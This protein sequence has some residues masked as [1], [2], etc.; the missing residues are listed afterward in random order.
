MIKR[1]S[2]KIASAAILSVMAATA[3]A[4]PAKAATRV[5]TGLPSIAKKPVRAIGKRVCVTA[6]SY[7][8][9]CGR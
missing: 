8:H 1:I 4:A 6:G 5:V 9:P 7:R 2:S 3:G